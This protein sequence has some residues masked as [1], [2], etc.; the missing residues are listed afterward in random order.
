MR[1]K[2]QMMMVAVSKNCFHVGRQYTNRVLIWQ[3]QFKING[4]EFTPLGDVVQHLGSSC[5]TILFF[6]LALS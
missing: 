1:G 6:I 3:V 2:N 4:E 5:K